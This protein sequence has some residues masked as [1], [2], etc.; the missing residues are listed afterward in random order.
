MIKV[1][2]I[3]QLV[4]HLFSGV[5]ILLYQTGLKGRQ[6]NDPQVVAVVKQW[7][8]R[9]CAIL[10]I[11]IKT[12]GQPTTEP[13]LFISNHISWLD[14]LLVASV[15][16]P[17]FLSKS[18][19]RKWPVIGWLAA[20]VNTLFIVRGNRSAAEAAST[21]IVDGLNAQDQILIFP[22][23]TTTDGS[24][25]AWLYPRL[26]GAAIAADAP[27]QPIVLHYTDDN[28]EATQSELVPYIDKQTLI[29]N[30]WRML[31]CK[32]LTAN[33]YFLEPQK[34]DGLPRKAFAMS[35]QSAMKK[36][37]VKSQSQQRLSH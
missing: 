22:E 6:V 37:L 20:K 4:V 23:G 14:I 7:F 21:G 19:V 5:M 30:L 28:T 15:A 27:V 35:L 33:V 11:T 18:E 1:F 25:I 36:T 2:K 8:R 3:L 26:L 9:G 29:G 12:H 32:N 10:G 34:A 13:A 31:D 17:R 24:D 16:N